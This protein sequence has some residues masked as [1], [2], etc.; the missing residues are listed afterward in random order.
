MMNTEYHKNCEKQTG[1]TAIEIIAVLFIVAIIAAVAIS[2]ISS[3]TY[4]TAASE[5]KILKA[6]I[7]YAHFRALSDADTT[8]GINNASWGVSF[9]SNSYTLQRNGTDATTN[10]PDSSSPKHN[11]PSGIS[12]TQ[13]VGTTITYNVWGI[14][15]ATP[16]VTGNIAITITD[17]ASPQTITVTKN[18]GFIP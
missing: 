12:I 17:G 14:P 16:P 15:S 4:Y 13:G 2:R 1:F 3:T 5:V 11:L 9:S 6:N 10:F 7:R 18:T 8:Y